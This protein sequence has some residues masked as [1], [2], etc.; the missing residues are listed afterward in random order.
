VSLLEEEIL[1]GRENL[2]RIRNTIDAVDQERVSA[3]GLALR[4]SRDVEQLEAML[5]E[6]QDEISPGKLEELK[7]R[8]RQLERQ[9]QQLESAQQQTGEDTRQFAGDGQRAYV[10]GLRLGGKRILVLLDVSSSMLDETIVNVIRRRNMRD[11]RKRTAP[12]WVQAVATVD[13][14]TAKFPIDSQYQIYLFNTGT[15]PVL[16]ET[17]G[18][19][20]DVR[21][22]IQLN[23][24]IERLKQV[25]P[26]DG[27]NLDQTLAAIA[28][29]QPLPDNIYLI[30]DGLPTQGARRIPGPTIT[31]R[32]RLELF[33]D[34]V[35]KLPRGV[36]VNIVLLPM[37]GDPLASYSYWRLA[38]LTQG[39]YISPSKDWP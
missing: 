23:Q 16:E 12:K 18:R 39:S 24:A 20:L 37:E 35:K 1:E 38:Q 15:K 25:V 17:L 26:E 2:V 6:L 31:G 13:W 4:I 11:E 34:A 5:E 19:W 14:L 9:K 8:I 10:T 3:E 29:L 32:Q 33:N 21:N 36:P 30:T 22:R 7:A 28:G 27:T